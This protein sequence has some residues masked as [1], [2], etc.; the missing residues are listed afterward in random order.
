MINVI[1]VIYIKEG[2]SQEFLDCFNALVPVVLQEEGCVA[3]S[4]TVDVEVVGSAVQIFAPNAYT[5]VERWETLEALAAHSSASHM[6][7]FRSKMKDVIEKMTLQ[8]T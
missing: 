1:A 2:R 6:T 5:I 7:E 4:P 3:Y 8:V